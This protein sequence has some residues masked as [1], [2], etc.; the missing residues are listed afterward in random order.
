[1]KQII[2]AALTL[3]VIACSGDA[4]GP[5]EPDP[6]GT[7][8][9]VALN[10]QPLPGAYHS[11][12]YHSYYIMSGTF[13]VRSDKSFTESYAAERREAALALPYGFR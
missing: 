7:Y 4:S 12:G 9:L 13:V 8:G 10:N 3:A 1:M 5:K 2:L 6:T 11:D